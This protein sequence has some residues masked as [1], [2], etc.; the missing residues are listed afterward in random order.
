MLGAGTNEEIAAGW[1][2]LVKDALP[3]TGALA[4]YVNRC[5]SELCQET[6]TPVTD[7]APFMDRLRQRGLRLGIATKLMC[8]QADEVIA[9]GCTAWTLEVRVSSTG[10][11]DLY[12][13]FGFAPAGV[14][15]RYYENT[16][17]AIVMWC[18]EIQGADYRRRLERLRP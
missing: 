6:T 14:R 4:D 16:E 15:K 17:D 9:R 5:F 3:Q 1:Q 12:R 2:E 8:A 10:A 7:L 13:Q 11:Q 18:H